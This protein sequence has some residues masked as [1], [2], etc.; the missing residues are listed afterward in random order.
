M[1]ACKDLPDG[2]RLT[3]NFGEED[4]DEYVPSWLEDALTDKIRTNPD[5]HTW[6]EKIVFE[7][8][9]ALA[10]NIRNIAELEVL[11]AL[12]DPGSQEG[13]RAKREMDEAVERYAA[14]VMQAFLQKITQRRKEEERKRLCVLCLIVARQPQQD[15]CADCQKE[16]WKEEQRLKIQ[17]YRARKA[18]TPATLTL[19]QWISTLKRYTH[20]CAYCQIGP[21]EV[22]EHYIPLTLGGGTTEENCV[23]AC[24]SCNLKK[25]NE[26]P[27]KDAQTGEHLERAGGQSG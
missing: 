23:P 14:W 21:Y 17:L 8:G 26:H 13:A 25:R 22:L 10:P 11:D 18:G 12:F 20:H 24:Q 7:I 2:D 3:T 6:H 27:E 1:Q 4:Y 16:H 15:V 9:V 5:L 19:G